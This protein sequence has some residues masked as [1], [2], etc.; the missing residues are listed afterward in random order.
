[1]T[2]SLSQAIETLQRSRSMLE[3]VL[4]SF[5][6]RVAQFGA[7][8][9]SAFW[10]DEEWQKR[11]YDILSRLFDEPD[12]LGGISI[13]DF[14]CGYGAFFDYLADRPVMKN[15]RYTGIDM[16]A[17]MIEE[18]NARIRDSRAT[19]QS[20]LIATETADYTV[21]CGTYNMNLG[22]NRDEWADYV[23]ASL[24]QLWSKTTKAMGFNMLRFDAPDQYPGLYYADGMEFVKFCNETLSPDITYTDDRPLPDWTIIIRR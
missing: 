24:E 2:E 23:K 11:R 1:M 13:T 15:S 4:A 7:D 3:P 10:K 18:A 16:S 5:E 21:V 19:F 17:A 22:A 12:R 8:P 6:K 9:R 14:G 20:H